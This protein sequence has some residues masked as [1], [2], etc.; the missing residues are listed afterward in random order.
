MVEMTVPMG[1]LER[2]G[3]RVGV[4]DTA[5]AAHPWLSGGW[6]AEAGHVL[7]SGVSH[8]AVAG[9]ATFIAG[10]VLREA[11]GCVVV[12]RRVLSDSG[13]AD[14]WSVAQEIVECGRD[15]LDVL[16]LSLFCHTEDGEAPL[17]LSRA[18][19]RLPTET[20]VV[21]A[22]GNYGDDGGRLVDPRRPAWPAA[23]DGVVAVGAVDDAGR[24]AP[25]SPAGVPW[26]DVVAAGVDCVSTYVSGSV[27][28]DDGSTDSFDGLARWSGTSFAAASLSGAIAA[29]TVPVEVSARRAWEELS[30]AADRP[31]L[32]PLE[33]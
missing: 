17:L 23:L 18:V 32:L 21:A 30:R 28:F 4:L 20:M 29:R 3:V 7:P 15:G 8:H 1:G 25:S 5:I 31:F 9:H 16:N 11:P 19:D 27:T 6:V 10:L 26:V 14:C 12:A 22:A 24:T 33:R 13:D 2:R